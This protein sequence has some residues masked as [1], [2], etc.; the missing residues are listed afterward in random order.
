[1]INKYGK[2]DSVSHAQ[3]AINHYRRFGIIP[4]M[5]QTIKCSPHLGN[6]H[7]FIDGSLACHWNDGEFTIPIEL[8]ED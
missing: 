3:K 8:C 2:I 4:M 6:V 7:T 5:G 1:M